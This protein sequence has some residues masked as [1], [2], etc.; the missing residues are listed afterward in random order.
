MFT[1]NHLLKELHPFLQMNLCKDEDI[2]NVEATIVVCHS[3][4]SLFII[5]KKPL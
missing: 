2:Y 5:L 1:I 4:S 3:T